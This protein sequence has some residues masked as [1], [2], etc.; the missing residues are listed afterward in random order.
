MGLRASPSTSDVHDTRPAGRIVLRAGDRP[1]LGHRPLGGRDVHQRDRGAAAPRRDCGRA[2]R[3]GLAGRRVQH[4]TAKPPR[5]G[6]RSDGSQSNG[7][8]LRKKRLLL[9]GSGLRR[10]A[11]GWGRLIL[12]DR[13]APKGYRHAHDERR[14]HP[15][16]RAVHGD[17]PAVQFDKMLGDGQAKAEAEGGP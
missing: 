16:A 4:V 10:L 8:H 14:A 12:R 6:V 17:R 13:H 2:S 15:F 9:Q 11:H 1:A 3:R 7:F 5:H